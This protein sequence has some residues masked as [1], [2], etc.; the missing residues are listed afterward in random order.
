VEAILEG[1]KTIEL[2]RTRMHT[3]VGTLMIL[4]S[5]S[6]TRS[7]LATAVL[8]QITEASPAELWPAVRHDAG[9]TEAEFDEYFRGARRAFAL[10]LRDVIPLATPTP[11]HEIRAQAGL[12]PPQSFRYVTQTQAV[13]L[14]SARSA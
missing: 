8:D 4:Y 12:E 3:R 9:V 2:R 1:T 11:L 10:Y 14:T 7:V 6:P 5:S 13:A